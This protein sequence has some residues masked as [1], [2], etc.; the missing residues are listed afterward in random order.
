MQQANSGADTGPDVAWTLWIHRKRIL[1]LTVLGGIGGLVVSYMVKPLFKSEVV[2]YPAVSNSVSRSMLLEQSTGRDDILAFGDE[3]D[4]EQLMQMLQSDRVRDRLVDRFDLWTAYGIDPQSK[5]RH[6]EL[7]DAYEEHISYKRTNL[8][9]VRIEVL[10][11]DPQ[12][13]ADM[14]NHIA[15]L[16]DAVWSEMVSERA[17]KGVATIQE[18]LAALDQEI[19]RTD[20]SLR[21]LRKLGVHD[22]YSQS[23]RYNEYLGA[24]ILKGDQRAVHELEDRF[25]M[26]ADLAGPYVRL[27]DKLNFDMRRATILHMKLEQA[28]AD[29]ESE[30]PH[31]FM[32]NYAQ[33]AD[34]KYWPK[35][36]LFLAV[37]AASAFLIALCSIVVE[38][39]FNK[40]RD[41]HGK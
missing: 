23:E 8:G 24:A 10:D 14:A 38:A 16:V 41:R 32:V 34:S 19:Q 39:N 9:S 21:V 17:A 26:L 1:V 29:M 15:E 7:I 27:H 4:A 40:I 18:K 11:R 5:T 12:R 35:R 13:A 28:T 31:K 36:W 6:S 2:M 20:D 22:Y 25:K 30:V 33:P 37:S 3:E